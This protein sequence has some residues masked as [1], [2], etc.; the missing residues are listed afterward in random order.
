MVG[1]GAFFFWKFVLDKPEEAA[2][3][4]KTTPPA[5]PP[6]P[7][8]EAKAQV[9]LETPPATEIKAPAGS[10]ET[11]EAADKDIKAGDTIATLVGAKA[12]ETEMEK[13]RGDIEKAT[14]TIEAAMKD[15]ADAQQKENNQ[16]GVTAAQAKLDKVKKPVDD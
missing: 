2:P 12:I 13:L 10:L 9:T 7:P 1:A 4:A 16:A 6:P 14:P 3:Q 11:I 5:P 15:L 8:A